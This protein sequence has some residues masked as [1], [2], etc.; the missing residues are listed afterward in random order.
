MLYC[1]TTVPGY[2]EGWDPFN[3][4]NRATLFMYVPVPRQE[5]VIQWFI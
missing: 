4:F 5:P 3:M 1:Y 2:G